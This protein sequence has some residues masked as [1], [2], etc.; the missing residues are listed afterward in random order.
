MGSSSSRIFL[1]AE[2]LNRIAGYFALEWKRDKL[3]HNAL[4]L[5]DQHH[6]LC[7]AQISTRE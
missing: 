2:L 6:I 5:P 3:E 4:L 7:Q 1:Y